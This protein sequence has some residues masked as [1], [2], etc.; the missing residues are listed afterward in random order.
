MDGFKKTSNNLGK[1][2]LVSW[3]IVLNNRLILSSTFCFF[4]KGS[5]QLLQVALWYLYGHDLTSGTFDIMGI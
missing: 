3:G 5:Y 2:V 4:W 1:I